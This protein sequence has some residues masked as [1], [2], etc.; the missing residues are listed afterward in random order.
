MTSQ[1]FLKA[2]EPTTL[3]A[4]RSLRKLLERTIQSVVPQETIR[5]RILLCFSEAATN[6]VLHNNADY[7]NIHFGRDNNHWWLK[8]FDNGSPWNPKVLDS[9][10]PDDFELN[11]SGRGT[12]IL[13]SQCDRIEYIAG[14][15]VF[16]EL[17][18][19]WE[20]VKSKSSASI[21]IVEDN[22]PLLG[23]YKAYLSDSY[24]VKIAANGHEALKLLKDNNI[25]L[26]ISDINMPSMDG[27]TLREQLNAL[28]EN[29]LTPF[30]F[31]TSNNSHQMQANA[32]DLG[33]D[34]Y[35]VKPASKE[36][37]ITTI[38][39]VLERSKQIHK[40]LTDRIDS[41]ITSSL[42]PKLPDEIPNWRVCVAKRHTGK[43]GGDLLLH[44]NTSDGLKLVLLDIMGHDDTAKFFAHAY[45]GYLHGLIQ[46]SD[47]AISPSA[48]L[49]KLSTNANKDDLFS[50]V[51]L[52]SCAI[53]LAADNNLTLASAGHPAPLH[54]NKMGIKPISVGG[55]LPG[56]MPNTNYKSKTIRL[57]TGERLALFTD[58]LFDSANDNDARDLLENKITTEL[59][60]TLQLPIDEALENVMN[61]FDSFTNNQPKDDAMLLLIEHESHA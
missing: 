8:I 16:N 11:E 10:I 53:D 30:V 44:H 41:G 5:K 39:R 24:D 9:S 1:L 46:S 61:L 51:T 38:Q 22:Q 34:D 2:Q 42:T 12:S 35:I 4:V 14:A 32:A 15:T 3:D 55:M 43:G 19:Y 56:L 54:I 50:K 21:L 23:V 17:Q 27:I 7:I 59:L 26:V 58:G 28:P 45:G 60:N 20:I 57:G 40:R 49:E 6:L 52:T 47:S 48:L 31:L 18:L 33:V 37:L 36:Q 29:A 25:D 13:H